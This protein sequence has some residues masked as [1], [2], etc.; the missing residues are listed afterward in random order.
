MS[1]FDTLT[2]IKKSEDGEEM[3][4]N[5]NK[6]GE[7]LKSMKGIVRGDHLVVKR[8]IHLHHVLALEDITDANKT[9]IEKQFTE[10]LFPI[11]VV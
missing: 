9:S 10:S 1:G 2:D 11:Y 6:L 3:A 8:T 4:H 5:D 7:P